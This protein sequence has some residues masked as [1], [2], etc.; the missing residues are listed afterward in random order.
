MLYA[1]DKAQIERITHKSMHLWRNFL[2]EFQAV[3]LTALKNGSLPITTIRAVSTH[4]SIHLNPPTT[5]P[6]TAWT[7]LCTNSV[8]LNRH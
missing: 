2:E 4:F 8:P 6:Y 1:S 5:N 7:C 3:S